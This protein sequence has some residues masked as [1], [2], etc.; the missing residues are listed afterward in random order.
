MDEVTC[1]YQA[2]SSPDGLREQAVILFDRIRLGR[3]MSPFLDFLWKIR[4]LPLGRPGLLALG[5]LTLHDFVTTDVLTLSRKSRTGR[6]S[7]IN[8]PNVFR[9]HEPVGIR[10]FLRAARDPAHLRDLLLREARLPLSPT[11]S[12]STLGRLYESL[13]AASHSGLLIRI[14]N[15]R[16][17]PVRW[18]ASMHPNGGDIIARQAETS[19]TLGSKK[20]RRTAWLRSVRKVVRGFRT[21]ARNAP[22][23]DSVAG[24]EYVFPTLDG[25]SN[26]ERED[27]QI[28]LEIVKI[29]NETGTPRSPASLS[30]YLHDAID[31]LTAQHNH[32]KLSPTKSRRQAERLITT[33]RQRLKLSPGHRATHLG[34]PPSKLKLNLVPVRFLEQTVLESLPDPT[35]LRRSLGRLLVII[36]LFTGR[37]ASDYA[38]ATVGHFRASF[39]FLDLNIPSTKSASVKG[40]N[41]PLHQL[42]P[43]DLHGFLHSVTN[44]LVRS[45]QPETTL[46]EI[47]TGKPLKVGCGKEA[48]REISAAEAESLDN[49]ITRTH[50]FRYAFATWA[51]IA[52]ILAWNQDLLSDPR[53]HPWVND[54]HFFSLAM[55]AEWRDLTGSRTADPFVVVSQLLGHTSTSELQRTYCV[56]W[57][58]QLQIAVVRAAKE[59][60]IE[61]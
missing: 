61:L 2:F 26:E 54:S 36:A 9:D 40:L 13:P 42:I 58:V 16:G 43:P 37:R 7:R 10:S 21:F 60:K 14:C 23:G 38:D 52:A 17:E 39:G 57:L 59:L 5:R 47:L 49:T 1:R 20:R 15:F 33:A 41:L 50:T 28:I 35:D 27:Y 32:Q 3:E 4:L 44:A 29:R 56:S 30:K 46:Y 45:Y 18:P 53:I 12:F 24:L 55:L 34:A 48:A 31:L 51:P 6:I 19:Q 8:V 22:R 25:I 11:F